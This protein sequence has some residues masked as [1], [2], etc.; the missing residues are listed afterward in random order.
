MDEQLE[1][2][3]KMIEICYNI[4]GIYTKRNSKKLHSKILLGIY[5]TFV[6][7][8][9]VI[10]SIH[11]LLWFKDEE[12]FG[13]WM[14]RKL[15]LSSFI[16]TT[17]ISGLLLFRG[18]KHLSRA[19]LAILKGT[20]EDNS[21]CSALGFILKN[22]VVT[23]SKIVFAI[24]LVPSL[25]II[26]GSSLAYGAN[27]IESLE[28][29]VHPLS[30]TSPYL[31]AYVVL[32]FYTGFY[33]MGIWQVLS[34]ALTIHTFILC[35]QFYIQ[36]QRL[37][38]YKRKLQQDCKG[39]SLEEERLRFESLL[40]AMGAIN[41]MLSAPISLALLII[42]TGGCL[43]IYNLVYP[44]IDMVQGLLDFGIMGSG[45]IMC[46]IILIECTLLSWAVSF[47]VC[48]IFWE[49]VTNLSTARYRNWWLLANFSEIS[50]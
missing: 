24:A 44:N 6:F 14:I 45:G 7:G 13:P 15:I 38:K 1:K 42:V 3:F 40:D 36:G 27:D 22:D 21:D 12:N 17:P 9:E 32:S 48:F 31:T 5:C 37:C 46:T 4:C 26:L 19:K 28:R 35:Q 18:F 2:V 23:F 11:T 10:C 29:L 8:S 49:D 39:F 33:V 43:V 41:S 20:D 30:I 47:Y 25:F 16:S 34:A 50:S